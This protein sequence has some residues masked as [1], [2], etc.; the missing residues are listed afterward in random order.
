MILCQFQQSS[1]LLKV[2]DKGNA[3]PVKNCLG[4][5]ERLQIKKAKLFS[6]VTP[7]LLMQ[8]RFALSATSNSFPKSLTDSLSRLI[9]IFIEY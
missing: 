7:V 4:D 1:G 5:C 6:Y 2:A 3:V 8:A 9:L